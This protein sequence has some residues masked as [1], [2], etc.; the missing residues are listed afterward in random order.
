MSNGSMSC[1]PA[2]PEPDLDDTL[3]VAG[4]PPRSGGPQIELVRE[5][6]SEPESE[7]ARLLRRR[8]SA[9]GVV[10]FAAVMTFYIRGFVV[11]DVPT[12]PLR[13]TMT[14]SLCGMIAI[15]AS[16]QRFSLRHLRFIELA[17]V[18]VT[19]L[20]VGM[21]EYD[22]I[23]HR[24]QLGGAS[25]A[26]AGL[27][28][29]VTY[30]FGTM[31]LYTMFIPNTWRR[32]A[33]VVI[34]LSLVP[35]L[36]LLML[37][38]Q[39]ADV[40]LVLEHMFSD[41]VLLDYLLMLLLGGTAAIY[42]AHTIHELRLEALKARQLG[43]YRLQRQIGSGGMGEVYLAEHQLL[44]RPCAIKVIR[45]SRQADPSALE[46]FEREVQL[47]A[48][49]SHPNTI[50]IFD[51]GRTADG[52]F[53]YVM[54][55]L[56]GMNLLELVEQYGPMEP[57]R[58]VHFLR[59]TARALREAHEMGLIHRDIKPANIFAAKRGGAFDVAKLLDFGLVKPLRDFQQSDL[60]QSGAISGSPFYISP[61]EVTDPQRAGPASD[62]Y[63][64]A[65]TGYFLL[66]GR[67]PFQGANSLQLMVAHVN[68]RVRPPSE[69]R[70]GIPAD[71]ET[72][73]IKCL[74]KQPS[75]RYTNVEEL[76]RALSACSVSGKWT[77]EE[78]QRWWEQHGL[79]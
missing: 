76:E 23:L 3:I 25:L 19:G 77:F 10:M 49:L 72:V 44:R 21:Y 59:Q 71:L 35:M 39:H 38:V 62:I 14:A 40:Q 42:G 8:L 20:F 73:L 46:R 29:C 41:G 22:L 54:E 36:V 61:E 5:G 24:L 57:A 28:G 34:P 64:L 48:Q 43:Q 45:P 16:P 69:I 37:R 47:T 52:T 27:Q 1:P 65:A 56:P 12:N 31:A 75:E 13:G 67:P 7:I 78:A 60:S 4:H 30:I 68:E 74:S 6:D 15:L 17:L 70:A 26:L 51:Y 79:A 33:A 58:V 32:A 50:D 63:S 55:F 11:G 53:Y 9:A 66:T 2:Q 18:G